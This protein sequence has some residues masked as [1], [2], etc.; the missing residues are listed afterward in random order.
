M[1][2]DAKTTS[3]AAELAERVLFPQA[4]L[5]DA[6][7]LVPRSQLDELAGNGLYGLVGPAEA[8]GLDAAADT[9]AEVTE[10]LAG[11]CL[12]T[13]FVWTQHHSA[14][15]AVR[16]AASEALRRRWL[17]GLC[18]GEIRAGVAFAGLRRQGPPILTAQRSDEGWV[19]R[20]EAPWVTGWGLT[21]VVHTA[22]R[23]ADGNVV[24]LLVDAQEAPGLTAERLELAAVNASGT[25]KVSFE[26]HR[27]PAG[28]LTRVES[29]REWT[30]RDASGLARNGH[31]A[32]GLARRCASMMGSDM[33]DAEIAACRRAL[34]TA[35]PDAMV[36]A[37]CRAAEL[38]V[39]AASALVAGGGGRSV[40][41][42][43]NAQRLAREAAFLLVFGQTAA[44][45]SAQL[46]RYREASAEAAREIAGNRP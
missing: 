19:L 45:R 37:R 25:V 34:A 4:L 40:L 20:G 32:L 14:V 46:E 6:A 29:M 30:E 8:G 21:D 39:R 35:G 10:L 38:G 41:L 28:R 17:P 23:D 27:V 1:S 26:G 13:A 2:P 33:F 11:G 9:V 5:T 16:E 24:W 42:T 44:I 7:Q 15:T 3:L 43:E 36:S 12:T 18:S 22:A 31:F